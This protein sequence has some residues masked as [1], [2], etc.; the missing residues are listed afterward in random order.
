MKA[1]GV[2]NAPA[3]D[4]SRVFTEGE[5]GLM[6]AVAEGL[7]YSHGWSV[8]AAQRPRF[9][10]DFDYATGLRA[11]ELVGQTLIWLNPVKRRSS[12]LRGY[13]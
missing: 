8:R 10:L 1:R 4:T 13:G 7:E 11:A 3:F 12:F 9:V 5:W 2:S 6:R